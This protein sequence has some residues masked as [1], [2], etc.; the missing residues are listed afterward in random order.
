MEVAVDHIQI[1]HTEQMVVLVVVE[2]LDIIQQK[3]VLLQL[4]TQ[5]VE[6]VVP[7]GMDLKVA[8]VVQVL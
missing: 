1:Q 3:M 8:M 5:V 2:T 7:Q 4:S 6:V